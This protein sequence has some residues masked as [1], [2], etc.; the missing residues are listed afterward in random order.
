MTNHYS[1]LVNIKPTINTRQPVRKRPNTA[2]PPS[3]L[4]TQEQYQEQRET[5]K[6]CQNIQAE[7]DHFP[8]KTFI[9]LRGKLAK[10]KAA[11]K[12]SFHDQEH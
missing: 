10:N 3:G 8:P 9:E 2:K 7:V 5:F 11:K 6:R 4:L 1:A 12:G